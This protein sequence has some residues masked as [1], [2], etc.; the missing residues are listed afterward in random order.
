MGSEMC[1]RDRM[2]SGLIWVGDS[3]RGNGTAPL[4][5]GGL[6]RNSKSYSGLIGKGGSETTTLNQSSGIGFTS[7]ASIPPEIM[8]LRPS[9]TVI[10]AGT[11]SVLGIIRK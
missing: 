3:G 2:L 8:V 4:Y 11:V 6:P 1:I 9:S 7:G 10:P 5:T